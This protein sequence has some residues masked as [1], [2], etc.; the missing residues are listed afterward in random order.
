MPRFLPLI[1]MPLLVACSSS[2]GA[3]PL[4]VDVDGT[5][6]QPDTTEVGSEEE[7]LRIALDPEFALILEPDPTR[8]E[9]VLE[10]SRRDLT[11]L[12]P[13]ET[14]FSG[15]TVDPKTGETYLLDPK[16]GIYQLSDT[17]AELIFQLGDVV[18]EEGPPDGEF[19]D[20]AALGDEVFALTVPDEGYLLNL[21]TGVMWAHFCYFPPFEIENDLPLSSTSVSVAFE[22]QGLEVWQ[23]TN[24]LAYEPE[25]GRIW[26][27]PRTLN[28]ENNQ[29]LGSEIAN[30]D[31][32][33]GDPQEWYLLSEIDFLAGGI[34]VYDGKIVV[35]SGS[36]LRIYDRALG[37]I[38]STIDLVP[39]GINEVTGLQNTAEG[40]LLVVDGTQLI[41]YRLSGLFPTE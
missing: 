41:L 24:A 33:T 25:A 8:P 16:V 37:L 10:V 31:S 20:I 23:M 1:L 34:A 2:E 29:V 30:F 15:V 17:K 35:A 7:R 3:F 11:G 21:E 36:W 12:V 14:T 6:Q 27:Q 19:S 18:P 9:M 28:K 22:Q 40:E 32:L 38:E 13:A 39:H 26:A 5:S 4:P